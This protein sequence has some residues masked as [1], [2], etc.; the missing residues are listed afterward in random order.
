MPAPGA[1]RRGTDGPAV[2]EEPGSWEQGFRGFAL[3]LGD[4]LAGAT[5]G[6]GAQIAIASGDQKTNRTH[7]DCKTGLVKAEHTWTGTVREWLH[8]KTQQNI[9]GVKNELWKYIKNKRNSA[10][11]CMPITDWEK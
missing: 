2:R 11:K 9:K 7:E 6:Q 3:R 10:M 5:R 4:G 1:P 8:S